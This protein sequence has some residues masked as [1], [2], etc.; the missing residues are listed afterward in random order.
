M[1]YD[2]AV[3]YGIDG[4][5]QCCEGDSGEGEGEVKAQI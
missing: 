1:L 3:M 4:V 2:N 5:T